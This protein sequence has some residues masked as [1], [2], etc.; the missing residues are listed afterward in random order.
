MSRKTFGESLIA[1]GENPNGQISQSADSTI[2]NQD[3][4]GP[5]EWKWNQSADG[6]RWNDGFQPKPEMGRI[7]MPATKSRKR[8]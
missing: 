1:K 7:V 8:R 4:L 6:P 2:R 3:G 5:Q